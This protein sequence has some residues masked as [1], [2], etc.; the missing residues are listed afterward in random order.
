M[1]KSDGI[2]KTGK[3]TRVGLRESLRRTA[4]RKATKKAAR[5]AA[6]LVHGPNTFPKGTK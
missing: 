3:V 2:A 1:A 4:E 5:A 6:K